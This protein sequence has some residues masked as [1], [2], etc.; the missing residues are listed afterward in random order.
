MVDLNE[1]DVL[2]KWLM[3]EVSV[4]QPGDGVAAFYG[5]PKGF[6]AGRGARRKVVAAEYEKAELNPAWSR[7]LSSV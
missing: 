4:A 3:R 6:A 5:F 7:V 2:Q 1:V